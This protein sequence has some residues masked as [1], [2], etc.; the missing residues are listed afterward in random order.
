RIA[1]AAKRYSAAVNAFERILDRHPELSRIHLEAGR[2]AFAQKDYKG[3]RQHFD[4]VLAKNP[5]EPVRKNI[6]SFLT[7]IASKEK[8]CLISG[9]LSMGYGRDTNPISTPSGNKIDLFLSGLELELAVDPE[10]IDRVDYNLTSVAYLKHVQKLGV[11]G[12]LE[13]RN[14]MVAMDITYFNEDEQNLD[15]YGFKSGFGKKFGKLDIEALATFN[16]MEKDYLTYMKTYGFEL[17]TMTL[18]SNQFML[19]AGLKHEWKEYYQTPDKDAANLSFTLRPVYVMDPKGT[20]L[21]FGSVKIEREFVHD[22]ETPENGYRAFSTDLRYTR[23]IQK[24][25]LSPYLG[26]GYRYLRYDERNPIYLRTQ[27]DSTHTITVGTSY[28]LPHN[29]TLD[30]NHSYQRTF[31]TVRLGDLRRSRT[32]LTLSRT[33]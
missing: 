10:T 8:R 16:G 20:N 5:P 15:I 1:Y 11:D 33:F 24:L 23:N 12:E 14:S 4:K 2:A 32:T 29:F 9:M 6:D 27:E 18:V 30:L 13:M 25:K 17:N 3:A 21:L 31:S 26:Y 19:G 22:D 28:K 7:Q